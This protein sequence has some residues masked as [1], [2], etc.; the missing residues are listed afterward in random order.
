MQE[1]KIDELG[2]EEKETKWEEEEAKDAHK[3]AK[4]AK[5]A[6]TKTI[7]AR[8]SELSKQKD[9]CWFT[10]QVEDGTRR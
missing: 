10:G 1:A 2:Q 8:T 5:P 6:N 9:F 4:H 3:D 7:K